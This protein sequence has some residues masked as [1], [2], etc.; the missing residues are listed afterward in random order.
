[1]SDFE[2]ASLIL[3]PNAYKAGKAYCVKPFDGS[4]DL[5]VVRNTTATRVNENG[6]IELVGANV[7][8]VNY[9]IGG[10]CPSWLIEPQSTN[11]ITHSENFSNA[12]WSKTNTTIT[13]NSI[14]SPDG[15]TTADS[16]IETAVAGTHFVRGVSLSFTTGTSYTYSVFI[17]KNTRKQIRLSLFD[18]SIDFASA[19]FDLNTLDI[20]IISGTAYLEDNGSGWIRCAVSGTSSVTT[21]SGISFIYILDEFGNTSYL[22]DGTS[23]IYI[24]GA[25]LEQGDLTSYIPTNGTAVTRNAD[26]LTGSGN[27]STFN[28]SEGTLFVELSALSDDGTNK[29]M[30]IN[31]NSTANT[32]GIIIKKLSNTIGTVIRVNGFIVADL[33]GSVSSQTDFN[34]VAVKYKENDFALWINGVEVATDNSGSTFPPNTLVNFDLHRG[35]GG[36]KLFANLSKVI[37]YDKALTNAELINLTTI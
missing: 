23:G 26:V 27:S 20:T 4:G 12:S 34:K 25:Q 6:L 14:V 16:L 1:M 19:N 35:D 29:R 15:T 32:V 22:G 5:T 17:K 36:D 24:W 18:G 37:Y 31:D 3:T 21:A 9:P 11:L 10:G 28:D 8:R 13:A 2:D 7:P 30:T 33:T